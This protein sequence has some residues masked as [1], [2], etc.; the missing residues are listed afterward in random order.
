MPRGDSRHVAVEIPWRTLAKIIAVVA[1]VWLWLE[2]WQI[3]LVFVVAVLWAVTLDP[4]AA[5]LHRKGMSR[6]ASATLVGLSLVVLAL[7]FVWLAWSSI[8]SQL[9]YVAGHARDIDH[10]VVAIV[11]EWARNLIGDNGEKIGAV[12]GQAALAFAK[13][14]GSAAVVLVLGFVLMVYLLADGQRTRGWLIAFVPQAR[15]SRAERTLDEAGDV[16]SAYLRGNIVTA[17]LAAIF[18]FVVMSLLKVPAALLLAL[19]AGIF[20]FI[21]LVG[22]L[23]AGVPAGLLGLTVSGTVAIVAVLSYGLYHLIEAYVIAPRVY[24]NRLELSHLAVI[25]AFAVGAELAGVIGA[26]VAL[27]LAAIYP[28]VERIWLRDELPEDTV[29][30]HRVIEKR[31]G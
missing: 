26:I 1:L 4:L 17:V 25:L 3:A 16:M 30:K 23:I 24:G 5:W 22:V 10:R 28:T 6:A 9:Q 19:L 15:R 8:A 12:V 2:L 20:D 13:S 31:V 7:G 27:P 14:A 21:P 29:R 18:V 11:P